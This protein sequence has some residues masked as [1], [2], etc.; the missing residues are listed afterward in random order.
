[1]PTNASKEIDWFLYMI[2][3]GN[4]D[5][6]TGISTDVN[7][8]LKEH[9][10]NKGAQRLKGKGPLELV[11]KKLIGSHSQALRVEYKIKKFKKEKK[12]KLIKGE[13]KL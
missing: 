7:R 1:V 10:R 3:C 8:R 6:Y 5:L 2:R 12:E 11:Y 4:G 9:T 13:I